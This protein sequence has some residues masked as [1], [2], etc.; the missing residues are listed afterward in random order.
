MAFRRRVETPLSSAFFSHANL[1]AIQ[2]ALQRGVEKHTGYKI[3]RQ[4]DV[5]VMTVMQSLY[6]LAASHTQN[7]DDVPREVEEL[8]ALVL[9]EL[10]PHVSDA[11]YHHMEYVK[12]V[13]MATAPPEP[14]ARGVNASIKG[15]RQL[16]RPERFF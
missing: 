5:E 10:I 11:V 8:N 4:S 15:N 16:V 12:N 3:D 6:D 14:L 7:P 9:D 2:G 1:G 13:V